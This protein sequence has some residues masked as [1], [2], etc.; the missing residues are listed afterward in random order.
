MREVC[1]TR[2]FLVVSGFH[3]FASGAAGGM[4]APGVVLALN[5]GISGMFNTGVTGAFNTFASGTLSGIGSGLLNSNT[6][7]SGLF[8]IDKLA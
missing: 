5:G 6:G 3:N 2:L 7:F 1:P 4:I 8:N